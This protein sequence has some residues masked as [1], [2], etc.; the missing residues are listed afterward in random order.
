MI[1]TDQTR[2][3]YDAIQGLSPSTIIPALKSAKHW[4]AAVDG[5]IERDSS[6]AMRLGTMVHQCILEPDV[7]F[8]ALAMD[9]LGKGKPVA[10]WQGK[11][12]NGKAWSEFQEANAECTIVRQKDIDEHEQAV[13]DAYKMA[14]EI[15]KHPTARELLDDAVTEVT[16]TAELGGTAC[17]GRLD[18]LQIRNG[19][20]RRTLRG[21][22]NGDTAVITDVK[23]TRNA[24][25]RPFGSHAANLN[26]H[27]RLGTYK[28]LAEKNGL[29]V[30]DVY[31]IAVENVPP[32]DVVVYRVSE[33][34]LDEGWRLAD[35]AL[36]TIRFARERNRYDGM[37]PKGFD[38]LYFPNWAMP[39]QE[40]D[41]A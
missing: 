14:L 13:R 24:E 36:Q 12:R 4:K 6:V 5:A 8:R 23:T 11:V 39:E 31:V 38:E 27:V 41:Y 9:E 17:K 22:N 20:N 37:C 19:S 10:I 2:A 16:L 34:V 7:D 30:D 29:E 32:H 28:R 1:K 35:Q 15:A 3:E 33:Q 18:V 25:M 26:Y 21:L 40:V